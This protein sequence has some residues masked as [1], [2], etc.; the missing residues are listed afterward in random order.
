MRITMGLNIISNTLIPKWYGETMDH[1]M[2]VW[3]L[4]QRE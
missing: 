2:A 4:L 3:G 1:Q